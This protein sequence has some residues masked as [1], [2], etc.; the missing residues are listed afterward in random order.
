MS[1]V[2]L[3]WALSC[4]LVSKTDVPSVIIQLNNFLKIPYKKK[5]LQLIFFNTC[6]NIKIFYDNLHLIAL[7][8]EK[9]IKYQ[10]IGHHRAHKKF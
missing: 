4:F 10:K 6:I 1:C 3:S 5:I 2:F 9:N 8:I 7:K